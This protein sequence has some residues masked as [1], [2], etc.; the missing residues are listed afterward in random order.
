M[1]NT[2]YYIYG[3]NV[4]IPINNSYI[5]Q[6]PN[7]SVSFTLTNGEPA[8]DCITFFNYTV[9]G[10]CHNESS[11]GN[12]SLILRGCSNNQP[13]LIFFDLEIRNNTAPYINETIPDY[14]LL[15]NETLDI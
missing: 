1:T 6:M 9:R 15:S 13:I 14:S 5:S 7:K 12:Y 2:T 10:N 8:P 11:L 3:E 4:T